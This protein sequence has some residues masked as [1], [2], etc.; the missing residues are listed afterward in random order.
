MI[1]R[2]LHW[3]AFGLAILLASAACGG[4]EPE[5]TTSTSTTPAPA[6]AATAPKPASSSPRVFFVEP[7]D[8]ATVKSPVKLRFGIESYELAAV[9]PGDVTSARKGMGHHHVGVDT[10]CLPVGTVIPKANP[11]VHHGGAQT[12]MDM[13]LTP[14]KHRLT[15]QLGDDTHTTVEGLCSSI[16]VN[17]A[18]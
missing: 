13:Q 10:E 4:S 9:P 14:G 12:E 8:G 6:P 5:S 11:W 17:V 18:E 16:T 2:Q 15:L 7:T 1:V 3:Q